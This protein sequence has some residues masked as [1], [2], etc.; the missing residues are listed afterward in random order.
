MYSGYSQEIYDGYKH[1][2]SVVVGDGTKIAVDIFRPTLGGVVSTTPQ[3]VLF[4][5][6]PYL[7]ATY[8]VVKDDG[9]P[10]DERGWHFSIYHRGNLK[11]GTADKI[12]LCCCCSGLQR[13][14]HLLVGL[15]N[16][17]TTTQ[18]PRMPMMLSNGSQSQ[19]FSNGKVGM[20]G[21]SSSLAR[22]LTRP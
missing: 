6:T 14:R 16:T 13:H 12:R 5:F 21:S 15:G 10:C 1:F 7:R 4:N 18:K 22:P 8:T 20:W 3:S 9:Q 17:R 19:S 2:P 11:Y